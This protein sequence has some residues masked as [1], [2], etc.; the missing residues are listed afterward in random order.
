MI[1]YRHERDDRDHQLKSLQVELERLQ[2][3]Q[4]EMLQ[5]NNELSVKVQQ[6]ERERLE[7]EQR[8][9]ELRNC[10]DQQ[11]QDAADLNVKTVQL[12]QLKLQLKTYVFADFCETSPVF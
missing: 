2:G 4:K 8:L 7:S 12:E 11:R 9:T 5:E 1:L 3:K 6:L 10:A